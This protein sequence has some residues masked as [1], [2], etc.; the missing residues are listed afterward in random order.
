M[1]KYKPYFVDPTFRNMKLM[2]GM[3]PHDLRAKEKK[4]YKHLSK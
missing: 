3:S 4:N 2:I 1:K